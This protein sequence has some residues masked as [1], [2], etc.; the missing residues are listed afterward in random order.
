MPAPNLNDPTTITGKTTYLTFADTNEANLLVNASSS[1]KALRVTTL[2]ISNIDGVASADITV[3]LYAAATGGT[4]YPIAKTMTVPADSSVVLIGGG[5]H[6]WLEEDR[7][8]TC[9]ASASGDLAVICSYEEV[10]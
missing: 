6:V 1:G 5:N 3:T 7:R 4:G 9:Q 2:M 8:I 10:A